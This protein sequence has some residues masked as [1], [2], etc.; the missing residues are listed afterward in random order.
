MSE[1]HFII[2]DGLGNSKRIKQKQ[3]KEVRLNYDSDS[4]VEDYDKSVEKPQPDNDQDDEDDM[5]A[6]E[7]EQEEVKK[8]KKPETKMLNLEEF[9]REEGIGEF[10]NEK[11]YQA[12]ES[13]GDNEGDDDY[14]NNI[15]NLADN[16]HDK[17]TKKEPKLEAFNLRDDAEEGQFD[18]DGNFIRNSKDEME[19]LEDSW[20]DDFKKSQ[21]SKAKL[22]Q[23][24][25]IKKL[26]EKRNNSNKDMRATKDLVAQIIDIL[27]PA[28]TPLEALAKLAP[29]KRA[30]KQAIEDKDRKQRV[31]NITEL[32]DNLI[33]DKSIVDAYDLSK[34]EFIRLYK[35]ETGEDYNQNNRKRSH[36]DS[37]SDNDETLPDEKKIWEFRWIGD[38]IIH[39]PYSTYEM[40]HWKD[41]YFE[42][43]VEVRKVNE[44]FQ[45]IDMQD[46]D[47]V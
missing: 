43:K 7:E 4:S 39:G 46:F 29:P 15:E 42:S 11:Q 21:V 17:R 41:T 33:N 26:E 3:R 47:D 45:H 23:E 27:E 8:V 34:E 9:E 12:Q 20:I 30:K 6:S 28:E 2:D 5:F 31:L 44:T 24:E 32:C 10:D 38:E 35:T 16:P 14:Y 36:S 13:E 18:I 40:K 19:S 37:E 1:D 25:R 22:A